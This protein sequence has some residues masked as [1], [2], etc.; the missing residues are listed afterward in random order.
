MFAPIIAIQIA[1][2]FILKKDSSN[3]TVD[4]Q[5][6]L[7]WVV[8]FVIYRLLMNVDIIIGNTLPDMVITIF[9]CIVINK[10]KANSGCKQKR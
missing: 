10:W 7:I 2:F 4:I 1:D 3:C 9:L 5:N 8:G 6:M